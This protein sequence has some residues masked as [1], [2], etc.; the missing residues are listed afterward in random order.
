MARFHIVGAEA[1]KAEFA[2]L[3]ASMDRS[4]ADACMAACHVF[5]RRAKWYATGHGGGPHVR[6][7]FLRDSIQSRKTGSDEAQVAPAADYAAFVEY[8]TIH[9]RAYPYM[10]PAWESGKAEAEAVLQARLGAVTSLRGVAG[11]TMGS[12][13]DQ[14]GFGESLPED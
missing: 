13:M 3:A 6:T 12:T 11:A 7:G 5:E 10:R 9:M 4:R 8:G 14:S 1:L 2:G